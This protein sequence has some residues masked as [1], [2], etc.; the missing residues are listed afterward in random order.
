M[1]TNPAPP[2]SYFREEARIAARNIFSVAEKALL[3]SKSLRKV[4]VMKATPRFDPLALDPLGIKSALV[5]VFNCELVELWME[6]SLKHKIVIANHSLDCAGGVQLTRFKDSIK[7][8]YDGVHMFGPS[9]KKALTV[10]IL[11]A[12]RPSGV[13]QHHLTSTQI[14]KRYSN[15]AVSNSPRKTEKPVMIS[16]DASERTVYNV[17]TQN[18]F[19]PLN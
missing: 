9:G 15:S 7:G 16:L 8:E 18:R 4:I 13:L 1:D 12:L 6:S 3:K 17:P 14:Y 5:Q 2:I 10:S 11:D 19:D